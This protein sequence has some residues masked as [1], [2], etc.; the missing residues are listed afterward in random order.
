MC[1]E[2]MCLPRSETLSTK[3]QVG[4]FPKKGYTRAFYCFTADTAK[5]VNYQLE[6]ERRK[7]YIKMFD[8]LT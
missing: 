3:K 5:E 6:E 4:G 1:S 7:A 8:D 2:T